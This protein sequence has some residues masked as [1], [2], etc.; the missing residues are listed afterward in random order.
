MTHIFVTPQEMYNNKAR[1]ERS[2]FWVSC[3]V[4]VE[5]NGEKKIGRVA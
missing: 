3:E 2:A 5:D 1:R 4:E